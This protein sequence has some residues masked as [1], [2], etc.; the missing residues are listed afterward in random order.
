MVPYGHGDLVEIRILDVEPFVVSEVPDAVSVR[1]A[2]IQ[3]AIAKSDPQGALR[4]ALAVS[5]KWGITIPVASP[6][7]RGLRSNEIGSHLQ[8]VAL[9]RYS[10]NALFL[11]MR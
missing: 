10:R 1:Q 8:I 5:I 9:P 6:P 3:E 11:H 4:L 2:V 7:K